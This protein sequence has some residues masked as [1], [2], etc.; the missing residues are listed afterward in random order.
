MSLPKKTKKVGSDAQKQRRKEARHRKTRTSYSRQKA[1]DEIFVACWFCGR[2]DAMACTFFR[3]CQ[4]VHNTY[5]VR[6]SVARVLFRGRAFTLVTFAI[7][8]PWKFNRAYTETTG[9]LNAKLYDL[10][11]T[12]RIIYLHR[13]DSRAEKG[14]ILLTSKQD[15]HKSG[16]P[17]A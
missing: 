16:S 6:A 1:R 14:D 8:R 11:D 13:N 4:Y 17:V 9:S 5:A 10:H 15:T 3:P 12:A 7:S 2:R